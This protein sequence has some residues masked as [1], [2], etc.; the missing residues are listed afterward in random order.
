MGAIAG[1]SDLMKKTAAVPATGAR[2]ISIDEETADMKLQSKLRDVAIEK[3]EQEAQATATQYRVRYMDLR[4][5]PIPPEALQLIPET[6]ARS[7]LVVPFFAENQEARMGA[8]NIADPKVQEFLKRIATE[9]KT[10]LIPYV[11]TQESFDKAVALYAS[12]PKIINVTRDVSITEADL[13]K[14]QSL[15]NSLPELAAKMKEINTTDFV[16]LVFAAAFKMNASDV[17]VEAEEHKVIVRLRLDG[18]LHEIGDVPAESW[19]KIISRI[20]LLAALKINIDDKPQDGRITL[21]LAEGKIDIRVSTIPT[22]YGESVVM[23]ILKPQGNVAFESLGIRGKAFESL[24]HEINRPNGMIITTGPT[25]SGKTT[26]LYTI[27]K[28]KNLPGVKIITLEDPVEYQLEGINQSQIDQ[29]KGYTFADALKSILRQDPDTCMVGEI[30]DLPT[31][32]VAIQAALTGHLLLSTIHTNSASGAIP[33]F[34]SMG[35]KPFL[36]APAL[37]AII[38]QRLVRKLCEKCKAVT[39]LTDEEKMRVTKIMS[40]LSPASGEHFDLEN[41]KFMTAPGCAECKMLGYK[42]RLGV[43][44]IFTMTPAIEKL[45]LGAQMSEYDIQAQAIAD[46]MVTMAQDGILKAAEGATALSEVFRVS[47]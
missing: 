42:G 43:Y 17:H 33:R 12:L 4:K 10:K 2:G 32:E 19:K 37:N 25:G 9:K 44:E 45:I 27:L 23:R 20:K 16:T 18:I 14:F 41:A 26:T 6:D 29:S 31:A 38:G 8:V 24:A 11:I 30:R 5:F 22:A 47:E 46:G 40:T 28:K 21:V 36:L 34:L 7:F 3:K 1:L 35:V 13:Q 15:F 39:P